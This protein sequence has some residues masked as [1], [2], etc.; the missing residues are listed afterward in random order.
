MIREIVTDAE[1]LG[2][3]S[4]EIDILKDNKEMRDI[5]VCLKDI[6]RE[7]N[8]TSLSAPQIGFYKRIFV[9]NFN[10]NLRS[11]INPIITKA[12]GIQLSR[13]TCSS[14]PG[15]SFVRPRNPDIE[16]TYQT[17]LGRSESKPFVGAS[18]IVFQH[19]LDHLDGLL[20]SDIGLELTEDYDTATEDEK[21]EL[22]NMYL[23]SLD[24]KT[25]TANKEIA[26]DKELKQMSDAIDFITKV[27]KGEVTLSDKEEVV[28]NPNN[29]K[30]KK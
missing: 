10:G 24:I 2:Y 22:I 19:A 15:K 16:V 4:D 28:A 20:L 8:L 17:P 3:R 5:I 21:S 6:I 30:D 14:I 26:E 29:K 9:I 23:D 27:Q 25:K 12:K 1:K 18:A 7:K 13:E 11:F